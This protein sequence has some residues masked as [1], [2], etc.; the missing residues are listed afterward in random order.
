MAIKMRMMVKLMHALKLIPTLIFTLR[1][2]SLSLWGP[3]R[4]G[5]SGNEVRTHCNI[6]YPSEQFRSKHLFPVY[7]VY[8]DCET[9][10]CCIFFQ[11]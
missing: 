9:N 11:L 8:F 6:V 4:K 10:F 3:C 7:I 5:P 2:P 1:T